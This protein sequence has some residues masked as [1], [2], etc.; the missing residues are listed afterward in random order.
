VIAVTPADNNRV[1]V[2]FDF[3]TWRTAADHAPGAAVFD[4]AADPDT[5]GAIGARSVRSRCVETRRA[6]GAGRVE[7]F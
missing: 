2:A 7:R 5:I 3:P 1:D 6:A 4:L